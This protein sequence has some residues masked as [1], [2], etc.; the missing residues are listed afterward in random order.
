[1]NLKKHIPILFICL[2]LSSIVF[3]QQKYP[4]AMGSENKKISSVALEGIRKS[5]VADTDGN[6]RVSDE[7]MELY[8]QKKIPSTQ[9]N[10]NNSVDPFSN[11]ITKGSKVRVQIIAASINDV[12]ELIK[13]LTSKGLTDISA[14]ENFINAY[15]EVS[16]IM[17]LEEIASIM[18][19]TPERKPLLRS[20]AVQSQA[21]KAIRADIA[22]TNFGVNGHGIKVGIL[23][24]SYNA[25]GGATAGVNKGELPGIGNPSGFTKPVVILKDLTLSQ[26]PDLSDEGR[27][28]A[29]IVHD[30]APGAEIYFYTAFDGAAD[31]ASGIRALANAGC[32]IIVDDVGYFAE[33]YFQDG[34]LARAVEDVTN[35]GVS[36]FTSAG[37]SSSRSYEFDFKPFNFAA[38]SE[39][40]SIL[41]N[42]SS[43]PATNRD[44]LPIFCPVG[45]VG[46]I[47]LQWTQPFKSISGGVGARTDLDIFILDNNFNI[48]AGNTFNNI[49][50]D[51]V[52]S[53]SFQ[54]TTQSPVLRV[55]VF[56]RSGT[57]TQKIKIVFN[58]GVQLFNDLQNVPG[59]FSSTITGQSNARSAITV[60]AA[61]Y[62]NTVAFGSPTNIIQEFSSKGGLDIL[63]NRFG[64]RTFERRFK[65]EIVAADN[66]NTSFFG[67]DNDG[68]GLPNFDGT[69]ASAPHAAA[70][71][72]LCLEASNCFQLSPFYV[73]NAFILN[74][75]DMDD[76]ETPGFDF[77]FDFK[78]GNGFINAE[79]IL[80]YFDFCFFNKKTESKNNS[81]TSLEKKDANEFS[82]TRIFP[83]PT[84]DVLNISVGEKEVINSKNLAIKMLDATGKQIPITPIVKGN[85]ISINV[86]A[87][88]AGTYIVQIN[89]DGKIK[90]TS[91][92]KQ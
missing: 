58:Q 55:V 47:T 54:N 15:I 77:G 46:T 85:I 42:F 80:S 44:N 43:N 57:N 14:Y 41:H 39:T 31:F 7:L 17:L 2:L 35:Q 19:V 53:V 27:G 66:G 81:V 25:L 10:K 28:M 37:N 92:I 75:A 63:F 79:G 64:G 68:D 76:P 74:A 51:P 69:S 36:Y 82:I 38:V 21:D 8:K 34:I 78:T 9:K 56:K 88:I 13:T 71:A 91:F 90:N 72:A 40:P 26:D 6:I 84:K 60:G 3:A 65:P 24:D 22:R 11:I 45:N 86:Q 29:E 59:L 48:I 20:G 87:L 33:P 16:K 62:Q 50:V 1:M 12:P 18:M 73:K 23:S 70:V 52:T 32:K 89:K 67:N 61:N 5:K 30:V 49:G 83:N 4:E